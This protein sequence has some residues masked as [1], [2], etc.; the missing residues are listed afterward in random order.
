WVI[1]GRGLALTA[2]APAGDARFGAG[3]GTQHVDALVHVLLALMV[4]IVTA[5]AVGWLFKL[6]H[7]PAVIGE[8]I[9]GILLGPSLL[10]R[11]APSVSQYLLPKTV[12]PF[13]GVLS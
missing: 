3:A 7:Q 9:A 8:I 1:R 6:F 10:G 13:L 12:A 11:V 2:P 5:R 4:V